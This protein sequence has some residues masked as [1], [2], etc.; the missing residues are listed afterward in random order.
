[1]RRVNG[2]YR[3]GNKWR[4][5]VMEGG[6]QSAISFATRREADHA[7]ARIRGTWTPDA[8]Q[9]LASAIDLPSIACWVYLLR[10]AAGEVIY[11]GCTKSPRHRLKSHEHSREAATVSIIPTPFDKQTALRVQA[12]LIR[13]VKPR[14]NVAK[15]GNESLGSDT[16]GL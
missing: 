1:M 8:D 13:R 10:D 7:M 14:L 5:N 15:R 6:S 3:H 4:L 12:A 11:V 9:I 2:P 16:R